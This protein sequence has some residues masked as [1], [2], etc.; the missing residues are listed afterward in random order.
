MSD[1]DGK[2][3]PLCRS[4]AS[5]SGSVAGLYA[6]T[7][8]EPATGRF[9]RVLDDIAKAPAV[10]GSVPKKRFQRLMGPV[11]SSIP[12]F[13]SCTTLEKLAQ[14]TQI[15][16]PD[17]NWILSEMRGTIKMMAESRLIRQFALP[18][19][20]IL[21]FLNPEHLPAPGPINFSIWREYGKIS[22]AGASWENYFSRE[23]FGIM[24]VLYM[25][26]KLSLK[27]MNHK[28]IEN[29]YPAVSLSFDT[30]PKLIR[31]D[32][33]I[34]KSRTAQSSETSGS[35]MLSPAGLDL[36]GFLSSIN[37]VRKMQDLADEK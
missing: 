24:V 13:P 30:L 25:N 28:L 5:E 16:Y 1:Y 29:K 26:Q 9:Q 23:A 33:V 8:S 35:Y 22:E 27:D 3:A 34:W 7:A 2:H 10:L 17:M 11:F 20:N 32:L 31:A 14:D 37:E 21:I 18:G 15:K 19:R 6:G 36:L 12:E 4:G